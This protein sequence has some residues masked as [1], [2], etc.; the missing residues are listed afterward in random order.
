MGKRLR[1]F[2]ED[3]HK[4]IIVG[5]MTFLGTALTATTI[6]VY[7]ARRKSVYDLEIITAWP[8]DF[9]GE[10]PELKQ[11]LYMQF[12]NG[13]VKYLPM[14]LKQQESSFAPTG[15]APTIELPESA[16]A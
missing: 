12:G 2:W 8:D 9:E 15:P 11:T 5:S 13:K 16:T 7:D 4:E 6:A 14:P 1:K 3:H 10:L